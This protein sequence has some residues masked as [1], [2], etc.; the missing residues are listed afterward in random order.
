MKSVANLFVFPLHL[1][2]IA[3]VEKIQNGG[4]T[5]KAKLTPPQIRQIAG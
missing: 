2:H 1:Y 3:A 5:K 4:G